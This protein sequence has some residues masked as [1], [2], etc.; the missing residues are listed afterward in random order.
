LITGVNKG[1]G[2]ETAKQLGQQGIHIIIGARDK[3]RGEEAVQQLAALDVQVT[4]LTTVA[5]GLF[6][7]CCEEQDGRSF[8]LFPMLY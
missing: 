2:F 5:L 7:Q 1:I 8:F 4:T 3:A 6:P